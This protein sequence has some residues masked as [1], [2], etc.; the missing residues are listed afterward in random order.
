MIKRLKAVVTW[1]ESRFPEKVMVKQADLDAIHARIAVV[2]ASAVHKEA[3][4]DLIAVVKALKDDVTALK[5]NLGWGKSTEK[6]AEIQAMLNG[7]II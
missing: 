4:Q 6:A 3:V 2:E 1:L 7:E 5:V